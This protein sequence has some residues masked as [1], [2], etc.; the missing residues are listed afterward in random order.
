MS[1]QP[2]TVSVPVIR[3][4]MSAPV[5]EDR[6]GLGAWYHNI[7]NH[8]TMDP[9]ERQLF[10]NIR[11]AVDEMHRT[12][13]SSTKFS[14]DLVYVEAKGS[15]IKTYTDAIENLRKSRSV[16]TVPTA[17]PAANY[18]TPSPPG[19]AVAPPVSVTNPLLAPPP[20]AALVP[21]PIAPRPRQQA[22]A[23]SA[24]GLI[25]HG[26]TGRPIATPTARAPIRPPFTQ[27]IKPSK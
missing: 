7:V 15:L 8:V 20:T 19:G 21:P 11:R 3:V 23:R 25:R 13:H 18:G 16:Q 12:M 4:D 26:S 22:N 24:W 2:E 5:W 10:D 17:V 6:R 14:D 1:R 27:K 9:R